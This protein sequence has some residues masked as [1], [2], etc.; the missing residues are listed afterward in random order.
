MKRKSEKT[1][2]VLLVMVMLVG[3]FP[4]LVWA[5]GTSADSDLDKVIENDSEVQEKVL[6]EQALS[7]V[8]R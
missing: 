3:V 6:I 2:S 4:G 5:G 8:N 1:I 7:P